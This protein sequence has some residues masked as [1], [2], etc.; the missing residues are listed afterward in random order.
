MESLIRSALATAVLLVLTAPAHAGPQRI[1][2]LNKDV[3]RALQYLATQ[4]PSHAWT[5]A[6]TQIFINTIMKD[7]VFDATERAL[8]AELLKDPFDL[9]IAVAREASFSPADLVRK[10]SLPTNSRALLASGLSDEAFAAN[11]VAK[12][13]RAAGPVGDETMLDFY[14][15]TKAE[16]YAKLAGFALESPAKWSEA[17]LALVAEL[18]SAFERMNFS[19]LSASGLLAFHDAWHYRLTMARGLTDRNLADAAV[20]I[21]LEAGVAAD[22]LLGGAVPNVVYTRVLGEGEQADAT[23]NTICQRLGVSRA[24]LGY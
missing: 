17:R 7:Q 11:A 1:E 12:E 22:V 18:R 15:R 14:L 19:S 4:S 23:L 8:V 2:S 6:Q 3:F 16:G 24:Q 20:L 21:T 9:V 5:P 13:A 10:G